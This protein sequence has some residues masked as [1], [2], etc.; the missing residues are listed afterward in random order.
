MPD[1]YKTCNDIYISTKLMD[2]DVHRVIHSSQPLLDSHCKFFMY[3]LF[4][5]LQYIHACRV[6]HRDLKPGNLLVNQ[7]CDLKVCD[8]GLARVIPSDGKSLESTSQPMT[9]YV[10]TRWYRAP[11]LLW[12]PQYSTS[13]DIWA[14]GCIFGELLKRKTLF[15][16][17]NYKHQLSVIFSILGSPSDEDIAAVPDEAA[18]RYLQNMKTESGCCVDTEFPSASEDAKDLLS[19]LLKF[20][21]EDRISASEALKHPY[22]R[23]YYCDEDD[24]FT[25]D[26]IEL[27]FEEEELSI[28]RIRD[29]MHLEM[30]GIKKES[31][32]KRKR[33]EAD[34]D[35][36]TQKKQA[37]ESDK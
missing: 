23:Q 34:G 17:N 5:A 28:E 25:V 15:P 21:P 31:V 33:K 10:V 26:E 13:I 14:A 16:G 3:Q 27:S 37:T 18:Q 11:E 1:D 4:K 6:I 22:L 2:L 20:K 7:N 8:F 36:S 35:G 29:L 9:K 30:E 32:N 24:V 19:K 12:N